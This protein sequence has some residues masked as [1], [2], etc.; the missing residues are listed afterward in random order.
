MPKRK[1]RFYRREFLNREAHHGAGLVY[2]YI[3]S[4]GYGELII[5]D[6]GRQ[7]A[8]CLEVGANCAEEDRANSLEKLD[9]LYETVR[10][11]RAAARRVARTA[12]KKEN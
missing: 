4:A 3:D 12:K 11:L 6:C 9:K 7:I 1:M 10:D 2:A 5:G 8:L